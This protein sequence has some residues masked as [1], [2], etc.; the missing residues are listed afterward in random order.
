[1]IGEINTGP[2]K[3]SQIRGFF[4][5]KKK[6]V[7]TYIN[8]FL[9]SVAAFFTVR[10]TF[11]SKGSERGDLSIHFLARNYAENISGWDETYP[12]LIEDKRTFCIT[13]SIDSA[14]TVH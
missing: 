5:C 9:S 6:K 7:K 12:A 10:K 3:I 8:L 11:F 13:S 1:M 14:G 4:Y 2:V